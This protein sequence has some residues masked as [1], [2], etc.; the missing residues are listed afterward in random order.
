MCDTTADMYRFGWDE[1]NGGNISYLLDTEAVAESLDLN[2]VVRIIAA[3]F[4]AKALIGQ[5]F[6]VTGTGKSFKNSRVDPE[7]S[8]GIIRVAKDGATAELFW[9]Y[10]DGGTFT[11]ELPAHF[12]SHMARLAVDPQSSMVL[13]RHPAGTPVMNDIHELDE[14]SLLIHYGKCVRNVLLYSRTV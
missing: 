9:G 10:S 7:N 12:M 11:S 3:G 5:I 4:E 8:P 14:K 1:R 6:I 13:H 2:Q